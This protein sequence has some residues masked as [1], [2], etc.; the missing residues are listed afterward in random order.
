MSQ[1]FSTKFSAHVNYANTEGFAMERTVIRAAV[2][3]EVNRLLAEGVD[4]ATI[5]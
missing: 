2:I 3:A 4:H 1:F 5:G